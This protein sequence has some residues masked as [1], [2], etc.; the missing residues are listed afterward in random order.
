MNG[1]RMLTANSV[2]QIFAYKFG[3]LDKTPNQNTIM[4]MI[5]LIQ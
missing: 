5:Q 3:E 1:I 4:T 2:F